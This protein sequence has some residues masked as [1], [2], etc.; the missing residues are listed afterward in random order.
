MVVVVGPM[1]VVRGLQVDMRVSITKLTMTRM[2]MV[3][4]TI[5]LR[6]SGGASSP[7]GSSWGRSKGSNSTS[8]R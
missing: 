6:S 7:H 3:P 5:G 8:G 1:R 4:R 2:V